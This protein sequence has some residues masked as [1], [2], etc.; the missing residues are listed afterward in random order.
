MQ[1]CTWILLLLLL[2]PETLVQHSN[3]WLCS[4]TPRSS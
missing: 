2:L 4:A 1:S 3:M